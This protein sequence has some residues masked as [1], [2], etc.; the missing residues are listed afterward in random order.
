MSSQS[1]TTSPRQCFDPNTFKLAVC[2]ISI[3]LYKKYTYLGFFISVISGQVNF[4]T[5]SLG[6]CQ[7][8][9]ENQVPLIRIKSLQ[10]AHN[11]KEL[12]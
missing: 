11:E 5:C 1:L 3:G 7:V 6:K 4:M 2:N 12:G 8:N 10:I 9:F